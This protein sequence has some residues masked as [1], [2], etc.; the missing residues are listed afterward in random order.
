MSEFDTTEHPN[1]IQTAI[2]LP[3]AVSQYQAVNALNVA[4][5]ALRLALDMFPLELRDMGILNDLA[6]CYQTMERATRR[7]E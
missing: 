1:P 4:K 5:G 2:P 3:H 7:T 6:L